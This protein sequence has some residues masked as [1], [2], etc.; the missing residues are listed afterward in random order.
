MAA[1]SYGLSGVVFGVIPYTGFVVGTANISTKN[2]VS[3]NIEDEN[4]IVVHR[5]RDD[6][7]SEITVDMKF[8]GGSVPS[9]GATFTYNGI[10][11]IVEGLDNKRENKGF[12]TYT[13]KGITSAGIT[14]S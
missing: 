3:V 4:G 13:V 6:T 1:Q 5:R 14:L 7:T 10:E 11:Y 9:V 2:N 12:E 8:N